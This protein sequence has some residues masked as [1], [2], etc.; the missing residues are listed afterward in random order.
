[1]FSFPTETI[2]THSVFLRE[3][4]SLNEIIP[5]SK[6]AISIA[7]AHNRLHLFIYSKGMLALPT[8]TPR[9]EQINKV[10]HQ[11]LLRAKEKPSGNQ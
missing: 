6:D 4:T 8:T 3:K 10:D 1:M 11:L 2:I 9:E 7:D 5:Y